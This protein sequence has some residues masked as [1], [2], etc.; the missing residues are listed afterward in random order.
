MASA[1]RNGNG[2][3]AGRGATGLS[4]DAVVAAAI[5]LA[6]RDGF[7]AVSIRR[8]AAELG[9]G[10]MN[11]YTHVASKD[12]LVSLM[13]DVLMGEACAP[14]EPGMPWRDALAELSRS[15]RATIVAH[16][17]AA[18]ALALQP[19]MRRN[20][21]RRAMLLLQAFDEFELPGAEVWE[22]ISIVDEYVLGHA[23]RT[24]T[25]QRRTG[26]LE[27]L[28]TDAELDRHPELRVL[29]QS[30]RGRASIER[31]EA[32]LATVLDG[33]EQRVARAPRRSRAA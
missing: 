3:R 4:E 23:I 17:W 20:A 21:A 6:D 14:T 30:R 29:A 16:P 11:L 33:I 18:D 13:F 27:T 25:A 32:G 9:T 10:H 7:E 1:A 24:T 2:A 19:A 15:F 12:D 31:F 28:A 22:L 26:G 5:A 8:V